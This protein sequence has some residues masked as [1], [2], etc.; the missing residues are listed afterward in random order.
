MTRIFAAIAAFIVAGS[1]LFG[2]AY[3]A[4]GVAL[5]FMIRHPLLVGLLGRIA[6][7]VGVVF[8]MVPA[9][10]IARRRRLSH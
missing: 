6:P 10:V 4:T 9:I 2:A 7:F 8:A 1:L 5:P 3:F